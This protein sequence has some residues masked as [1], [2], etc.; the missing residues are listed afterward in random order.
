LGALKN[1]KASGADSI[2]A[3]LLRYGGNKV[4][5]AIHNLIN[6]IWDLEQV[7]DEW[8]KS[9]I[10]P[11]RKKGDKLSYENCRG[12]TLLC[13]TYKALTNIICFKLDPYTENVVGE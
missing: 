7:P 9:I 12:I 2:P 6:L 13:A 4:I 10:C 5:N 11:I 1:H 3:E 8:R